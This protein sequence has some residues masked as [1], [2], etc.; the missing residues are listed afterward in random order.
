[1]IYWNSPANLAERDA[2]FTELLQRLRAARVRNDNAIAARNRPKESGDPAAVSLS[3]PEGP[4]AL[5]PGALNA[6]LHPCMLPFE[7]F[8][9]DLCHKSHPFCD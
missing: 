1:M 2:Y 3:G 4:E 7:D 8:V 5:I 6:N 9:S